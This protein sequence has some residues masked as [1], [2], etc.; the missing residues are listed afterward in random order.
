MEPAMMINTQA[1]T[2]L[3]NNQIN[4]HLGLIIEKKPTIVSFQN[5]EN[6]VNLEQINFKE[7]KKRSV[8]NLEKIN[9]FE[10]PTM[11]KI[12]VVDDVI[13]INDSITKLL[14]NIIIENNMKTEVIQCLDGVDLL[15]EVIKDQKLGNLID[16]IIADENMDF[17][18][19]T[20]AVEIL[21]KIERK[22]QI[23]IPY[24]VSS[25]TDEGVKEKLNSLKVTKIL[26]KPI[27]KNS[28]VN[29]LKDLK[30]IK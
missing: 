14:K 27:N 16:L 18:N 13:T 11:R 5:Q 10:N 28:F 26:P 20:E 8:K 25:T 6:E 12:L 29:V 17:L 4:T 2:Q 15:S 1:C 22:K 24:I 30:M 23:K 9:S 21:R 7:N 3:S 19:G